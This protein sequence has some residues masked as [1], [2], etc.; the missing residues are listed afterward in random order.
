MNCRQ[1]GDVRSVCRSYAQLGKPALRERANKFE[2]EVGARRICEI[3]PD[4]LAAEN[5]TVPD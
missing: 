5:I 3:A 2:R 1:P 4:S